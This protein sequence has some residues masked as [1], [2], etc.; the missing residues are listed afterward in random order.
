[1]GAWA[2]TGLVAIEGDESLPTSFDAVTTLRIVVPW[3]GCANVYEA[4][5]APSM[6]VHV[7]P[8]ESQRCHWYAKLVGDPDH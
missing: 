3:S 4:F 1:V 2:A 6:S 8:D 7:S 5:V